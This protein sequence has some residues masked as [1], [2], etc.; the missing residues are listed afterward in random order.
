MKKQEFTFRSTDGK[1]DIRAMR[2]L[3]AGKPKAVLQIAHGMVEFI[4][5]YENFADYLCGKGFVVTGNDHL[6]HGGSV[7]TRDDWG[8]FG[9]DGN[10]HVLDDMHELTK[11]TKEEYPG[12]PYFLLG[13]SMGSFYARQYIGTYGD[14]LTGAIIM[15]TGLEPLATI[16][17][18]MFLCKVI[19]LFKGW[20][21]RSSLVNNIAFGSYNK[22]FEPARTKMDW[23]TKDE[24]IVDWYINE[25]RCTFMFTLN[26]YYN[27]FKGIS[28]L[29]DKDLLNNVPKDL[30]L[31]FV[32]GQ[33][34]PVGTNGKEVE[35]SVQTLKD[36]GVRNIDL[37]L[38]PGD[39]HEILNE[40][41]K[42]VV[43][44]DLYN[45]KNDKM[46]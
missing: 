35:H 20:R 5:R 34:D 4:D 26:G 11:L 31:F 44:D 21:Y 46:K 12:L 24:K 7:K 38:Y 30:P 6:G 27:M 3:P 16:K 15:G 41:D 39:R 13:H 42:D 22:Q 17:A 37:K 19:A 40:L 43:Y 18:G 23:L 25:P 1:N 9:E 14:E 8:Y 45:W 28:R 32:S 29:Y 10:Q 33:E 36:A 2:Y